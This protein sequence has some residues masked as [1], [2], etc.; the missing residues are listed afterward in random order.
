MHVLTL[1]LRIGNVEPIKISLT[2]AQERLN[3][4][5]ELSFSLCRSKWSTRFELV[6]PPA[7][8]RLKIGS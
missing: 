3:L 5:Q 4:C 1:K 7:N 8:L 6:W 2:I